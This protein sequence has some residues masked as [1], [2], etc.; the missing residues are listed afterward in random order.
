MRTRTV[1]RARATM[2]V[3]LGRPLHLMCSCYPFENFVIFHAREFECQI[4]LEF[5]LDML[6]RN[7]HW[8]CVRSFSS[9]PTLSRWTSVMVGLS[10]LISRL[11]VWALASCHA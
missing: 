8:S 1:L 2:A 4:K 5:D 3:G 11:R 6:R 10:P 7:E 9:I